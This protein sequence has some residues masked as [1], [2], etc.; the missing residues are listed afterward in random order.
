MDLIPHEEKIQTTNLCYNLETTDNCLVSLHDQVKEKMIVKE[1]DMKI[2]EDIFIGNEY[3]DGRDVF[4]GDTNGTSILDNTNIKPHFRRLYDMDLPNSIKNNVEKKISSSKKRI[5]VVNDDILC[6]FTIL[7]YM[8]LKLPYDLYEIYKKFHLDPNKSNVL[9]L[10]S[11]C[12]TKQTIVSEQNMTVN[13]IALKSTG[14]IT[15]FLTEYRDKHNIVF[16]MFDLM[17]IK[18]KYFSEV[19]TSLCSQLLNKQPLDV[20][21]SIIY[22]YIINGSYNLKKK[23]FSKKIFYS[24]DGV[25]KNNF[26][27]CIL[28]VNETFTIIK[29]NYQ[30]IYI[31]MYNYDINF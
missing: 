5:H 30:D 6:A 9:E 21:S 10:I 15:Q 16:K 20:A 11:N 7:S 17:I 28:L 24:M 3:D 13:V 12:T 19:L 23:F 26:E 29:N 22:S 31:Y 14:Y 4:Y 25:T 27:V 8:E 1:N 2:D 18:I